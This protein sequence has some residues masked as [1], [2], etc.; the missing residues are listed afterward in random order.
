MNGHYLRLF[1]TAQTGNTLTIFLYAL[2]F[3]ALFTQTILHRNIWNNLLLYADRQ[4]FT[5]PAKY[6]FLFYLMTTWLG[7]QEISKQI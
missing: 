6:I 1:F 5:L 7:I 3:N 4:Y 2:F